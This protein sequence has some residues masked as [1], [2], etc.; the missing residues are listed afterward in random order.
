LNG[1]T[2]RN[3]RLVGSGTLLM[4]VGIYC[5]AGIRAYVAVFEITALA[6]AAAYSVVFFS[7][8]RPRWGAALLHAALLTVLWFL[9]VTGA[10]PYAEPYQLRS[11]VGGR[12]TSVAMLDSARSGFVATGGATSLE[13]DDAL[14]VGDAAKPESGLGRVERL[15]RGYAALFIPISALRA[16]SIVKFKGGAGLLEITDIDTIVADLTVLAALCLFVISVRGRGLSP[17]PMFVLVLAILLTGALAYVVT[18][19]GTLF[20]LRLLGVTPLWML[21]VMIPTAR[22]GRKT[23][24][25]LT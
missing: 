22:A 9:F 24:L 23:E 19:Y 2:A 25:E 20:R 5:V 7:D 14:L 1:G 15:G 16:A 4:A 12:A 10:G 11:F 6:A 13:E 8:A 18:N 21:P 3:F 17:G